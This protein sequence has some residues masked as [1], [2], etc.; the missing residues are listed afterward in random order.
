M[1][2]PWRITVSAKLKKIV[3]LSQL[4]CG[5]TA[6]RGSLRGE[7][8][9][10]AG[11]DGTGAEVKRKPHSVQNGPLRGVPHCVQNLGKPC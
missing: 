4:T 5:K 10:L 7:A 1:P 9:V 8:E 3:F 11:I 2:C 6:G